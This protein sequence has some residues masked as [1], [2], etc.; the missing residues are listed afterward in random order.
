MISLFFLKRRCPK[1]Q[2]HFNLVR[3][4]DIKELF[5]FG[6]QL[7]ILSLPSLITLNTSNI[8]I[9][10][11]LGPT[12]VTIFNVTLMAAKQ[13]KGIIG[14]ATPVMLPGLC[15]LYAQRDLRVIRMVFRRMM[16]PMIIINA[17][18]F[19]SGCIP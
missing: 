2:V 8:I 11:L 6:S 14:A 4:I 10:K 15:E 9:A 3:W 13:A 18:L 16:R 1:L 17:S 19:S 12:E 5:S 7:L